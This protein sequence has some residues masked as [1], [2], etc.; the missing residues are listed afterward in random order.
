MLDIV[1]IEQKYIW[2]CL[3]HFGIETNQALTQHGAQRGCHFLF[4][5]PESLA[6]D[7]LTIQSP[8]MGHLNMYSLRFVFVRV[9]LVL[10]PHRCPL[11]FAI[12]I[13]WEEILNRI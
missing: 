13:P 8:C 7:D 6:S 5:D 1:R 4:N 10:Q 11:S 2:W 12:D 3:L 9:M